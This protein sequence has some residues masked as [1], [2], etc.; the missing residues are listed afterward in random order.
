MQRASFTAPT[1]QRLQQ[2]QSVFGAARTT[3]MPAQQQRQQKHRRRNVSA[4]AAAMDA[5]QQQPNSNLGALARTA[6]PDRLVD[7]DPYNAQRVS[8]DRC[9][10]HARVRWGA[11]GEP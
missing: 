11:A 4:T 1:H 5:P 9:G 10:V 7:I 8:V 2:R 3:P 6:V